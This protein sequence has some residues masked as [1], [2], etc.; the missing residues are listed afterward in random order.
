MLQYRLKS[1]LE[2]IYNDSR[3]NPHINKSI[4]DNV[5]KQYLKKF[6]NFDIQ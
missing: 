4:E 2:T 5:I 3:Y 6:P 1:I